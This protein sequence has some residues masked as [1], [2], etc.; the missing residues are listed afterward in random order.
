MTLQF[1]ISRKSKA[2]AGW[3]RGYAADCKSVKTGSI[4][5]PASITLV[6]TKAS[7]PSPAGKVSTR[8]HADPDR[9]FAETLTVSSE[10]RYLRAGCGGHGG[11]PKDDKSLLVS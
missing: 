4:P 10:L 11:G 1:R 8:S 3:R 7:G 2:L 5:V 9:T 6:D